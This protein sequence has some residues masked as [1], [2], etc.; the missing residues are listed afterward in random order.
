MFALTLRF[1]P[2]IRLIRLFRTFERLARTFER[3][4]ADA[5]DHVADEALVIARAVSSGPYTALMLRRMGHP[6]AR[7][8][9][10]PPRPLGV[11]NV[12]SGNFR[13]MWRLSPRSITRGGYRTRLENASLYAGFLAQGTNRMIARPFPA[14]IRRRLSAR[15]GKI[16]TNAIRIWLENA[17]QQEV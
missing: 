14:L 16:W 10:N 1:L 15:Q 7:T 6:Y 3:F 11:I 13:N 4:S 12:Q 17:I 8:R 5:H 2:F 9:G